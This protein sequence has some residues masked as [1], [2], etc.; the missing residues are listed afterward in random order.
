VYDCSKGAYPQG[1]ESAWCRAIA[2][3][4]F[5]IFDIQEQPEE[6]P[7]VRVLR[8]RHGAHDRL[9]AENIEAE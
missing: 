7:R 4:C 5:I 9:T 8:I 3:K 2:S 6:G 1:N